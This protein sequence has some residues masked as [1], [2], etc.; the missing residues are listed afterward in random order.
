MQSVAA[1]PIDRRMQE[2]RTAPR[3]RQSRW[4]SMPSSPKPWRLASTWSIPMI[5]PPATATTDPAALRA[6]SAA[7]S[8]MSTGG[9][10]AIPSRSAATATISSA[11]ARASPACACLTTYS[12]TG[13]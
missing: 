1:G 6:N 4:T 9:S 12:V 3:P 11:I 8:S 7:R 2:G 5:W 10:V 13:P